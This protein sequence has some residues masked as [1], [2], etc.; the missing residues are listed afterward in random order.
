MTKKITY[1][2]KLPK[3]KFGDLQVWHIPQVPGDPF[4]VPVKTV[5][6][7]R[8]VLK[9]LAEYDLFQLANNIKPDYANAQGLVQYEHH[10][11]GAW[12]EWEDDDGNYINGD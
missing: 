1:S 2:Q 8:L 12:N 10:F 3:P 9:A 6:E 4:Y 7:A 11:T 5:A